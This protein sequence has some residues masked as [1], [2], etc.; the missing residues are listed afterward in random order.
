MQFVYHPK[1]GEAVLA[2]DGESYN[3]IFKVRR[4]KRGEIIAFRNLKDSYLY[5]YKID[6][7]SRRKGVFELI[8]KEDKELKPK[9][10]FHLFW[11][12]IEPKVIE[13]TLPML[14]E[15]GVGKIS[16]VYCAR[17]QKNFTIKLDRL[18]KILINSCQQCGRSHLMELEILKD[19]DET[20]KRYNDIALIDFSEKKLS[21]ADTI[22]KALIGPEGGFTSSERAKFSQIFGLDSFVLR[23][24]TA[25]VAVSAKVLA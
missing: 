25:A 10:S 24:E 20:L 6:E 4:H 17:S 7:V 21:C 11:C 15:I 18:R 14:N 12:V 22:T 19:L 3:Y 9:R 16:F 2:V 8:D 5:F 13:K 23:S 1:A